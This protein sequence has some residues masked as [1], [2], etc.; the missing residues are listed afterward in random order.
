M[1]PINLCFEEL[2]RYEVIEMHTDP[3]SCVTTKWAKQPKAPLY[4]AHVNIYQVY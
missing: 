3:D 1:T 4:K 2:R